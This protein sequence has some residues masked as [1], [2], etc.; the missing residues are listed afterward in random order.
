MDDEPGIYHE[1]LARHAHALLGA[2]LV[3]P[4]RSCSALVQEL[5]LD[6]IGSE[7]LGRVL[8]LLRA[9]PAISTRELLKAAREHASDSWEILSALEQAF[10]WNADYH[11]AQIQRLLAARAR[12]WRL[13][14]AA[15]EAAWAMA[16]EFG[17]S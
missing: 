9:R 12:Y 7:L 17:Q 14:R 4:R 5:P 11:A 6:A 3:E 2:L 1:H 13:R 8:S 16:E 15:T 10:P